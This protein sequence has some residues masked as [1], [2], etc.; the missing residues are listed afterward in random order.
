MTKL[1]EL[2]ENGLVRRFANKLSYGEDIIK[3]IGDDCAVIESEKK[4]LLLTTDMLVSGDHFNTDWQSPWQ[5]GWKSIV[6]NVSDI[7]AMGGEPMYG[8]ISIALPD[9]ISVE[10][11]DEVFDGFVDASKKYGLDL[12]GGDT[13]HGELLVI[14]VTILGK[15][16][17]EYISLRGDAKVGDVIAVSGDLGKSWAGLELLRAGREGYTDYY[18]EPRCRLDY[19]RKIA[20]YVNALIDVSDG[21]AS[22]VTHICEE[23][24]V[25][26]NVYLEKIPISEKTRRTAKELD[27]DPYR[28]ALSGGEDFELVFTIEKEK[29]AEIEDLEYTVVGEITEEGL[30]LIDGERKTLR[31]GYDHF[32]L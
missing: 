13:T 17:K 28:W 29:L 9:D 30:Y 2:G 24:G 8:L 31:G 26:A 12:V 21:L 25:G 7:A 19:A 15:V 23:S 14:N 6:A 16:E 27:K 5:I 18:L 32:N 1:S 22:E 20:P 11:I 3:G 10:F 4:Y